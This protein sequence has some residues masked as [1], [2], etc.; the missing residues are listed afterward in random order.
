VDPV[1]NI[2]GGTEFEPGPNGRLAPNGQPP[3]CANC[4]SLE[5][6]RGLRRALELIP[7]ETFALRRALQF[8]PESSLDDSW[9]ESFERSKYEGENSIDL[10]EPIDRPD[11]SYDFISLSL[12][13]EF[14]PDD[15]DAFDELLRIGSDELILHLTFTSGLREKYS[16]HTEEPIGEF[17][18]YHDYGW[19]F[20]QWFGT[21]ER[22]LSI[23]VIDMPDPVTGDTSHPFVFFFRRLE[24]AETFAGTFEASPD[25]KIRTFNRVPVAD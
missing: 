19:D 18:T 3:R 4:E 15:R 8:A 25:A 2:C 5:R 6:H 7:R 23:L 14:V 9:F 13:I 10:A 24:D 21:A 12:V 17:G 22:G 16:R 11:G 1:C 20:D